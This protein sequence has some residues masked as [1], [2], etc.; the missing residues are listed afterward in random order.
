[1][2]AG[3]GEAVTAG[4]VSEFRSLTS[5]RLSTIR[6]QGLSDQKVALI[7][8]I[9]AERESGFAPISTPA[10]VKA[11]A[12]PRTVAGVQEA[13]LRFFERETARRQQISPVVST[14]SVQFQGPVRPTTDI[15]AFRATGVSKPTSPTQVSELPMVFQK[16]ADPFG[17]APSARALPKPKIT[18][19]KVEAVSK[20]G[21]VLGTA[22]DIIKFQPSEAFLPK[23]AEAERETQQ[24]AREGAGF[25]ARASVQPQTEALIGFDT[26]NI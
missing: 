15:Q 5:E 21:G 4:V 18:P 23:F 3:V 1:M 20:P 12:E 14:P 8:T 9:L 26:S 19:S 6:G 13:Q 2:T 16:P 11:F 17:I 25:L 24:F 7:D 22:R 10:L